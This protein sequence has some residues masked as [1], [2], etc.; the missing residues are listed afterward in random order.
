MLYRCQPFPPLSSARTSGRSRSR[1]AICLLS[2][3]HH[4]HHA[5]ASVEAAV[6]GAGLVA[7]GGATQSPVVL[8]RAAP[9]HALAARSRPLGV[10]ARPHPVSAGVVPVLAPLPDVAVHVPKP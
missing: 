8:P 3:L 6:A 9:Q 4:Q 10:A 1:L 7:T 5:E 2:P